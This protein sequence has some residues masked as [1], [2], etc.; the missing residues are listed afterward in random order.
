MALVSESLDLELDGIASK[1]THAYFGR[2]PEGSLSHTTEHE[3]AVAILESGIVQFG[4]LKNAAPEQ[5]E[6]EY[7]T[8]EVLSV[9]RQVQADRPHPAIDL[10]LSSHGILDVVRDYSGMGFLCLSEKDHLFG[11]FG[12]VALRFD[13]PRL[14]YESFMQSLWL[15]KVDYDIN[16][17]RTF[18]EGLIHALLDA[19]ERHPDAN[20]EDEQHVGFLAAVLQEIGARQCFAPKGAPKVELEWRVICGAMVKKTPAS[21]FGV[22][23]LRKGRAALQEVLIAPTCPAESRDRIAGVI[24]RDWP[25]VALVA[26]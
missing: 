21:P 23:D 14:S 19:F 11:A 16:V 12:E 17:V 6:V 4:D 18:A 26:V 10:L 20:P 15:N 3:R 24:E 8:A 7:C 22:F 13:G 5:E 1:W 25:G 9:A 2:R